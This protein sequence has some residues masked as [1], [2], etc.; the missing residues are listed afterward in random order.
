MESTVKNTIMK[1]CVLLNLSFLKVYNYTRIVAVTLLIFLTTG[2]CVLNM[3]LDCTLLY[4][5]YFT[6]KCQHC[7]DHMR[8]LQN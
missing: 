5:H 1:I 3:K 7:R 2:S 4:C 6:E 8:L